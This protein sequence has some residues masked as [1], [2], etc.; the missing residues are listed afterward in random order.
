MK[1]GIRLRLVISLFILTGMALWLTAV[2]L[3]K[4]AEQR[5][6]NHRKELAV[7][8]AKTLA[9]GSLDALVTGDFELLERWV[10]SS[11]PTK[12][13]AYAALVRPNGQVL[14]HTNLSLIGEKIQTHNK[15]VDSFIRQAQYQQRPV[16]EVLYSST[17]GKKHLANAHVAYYLDIPY[18]QDKE[19]F[20]RLI[21][22]MTA[23]SLF[24]M[25]GVYIVTD[26]IIKPIR[27]LSDDIS[28][29]TLEK[30]IRFSPVVYN[31][32]DEIGELAKSFDKL[33]YRLIRS[34]YDLKVS[35]DDAINA[36]ELAEYASEAKSDFIANISHE[37]RTPMHSILGF[38]ELGKMKAESP[39]K[40]IMYFEMI[41]QSGSRLLDLIN[42]LLD[43]SK[44]GAGEYKINKTENDLLPLVDKC[45]QEMNFLLIEKSIYIS[46]HSE[47]EAIACFDSVAI[48]RVINNLMSNAIKYCNS[49]SEIVIEVSIENQFEEN[50]ESNEVL[51]FKIRDEGAGIPEKEL[52]TIFDN[53]S[54][55]STTKDGAGGTGLGLTISKRIIEAHH[56]KLWAENSKDKSG[57]VFHFILP[58]EQTV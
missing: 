39:E 29:F 57:V 1:I 23:A 54:Q 48:C 10:A 31:R 13:Y 11:L 32:K 30:G 50:D 38:S 22:I 19:T 20:Y 17:L 28:N 49:E 41:R 47:K 46:L 3:I 26:K 35:H 25:I 51:H 8:Q 15:P 2:V 37:L 24:L 7:H 56:G 52:L 44:L 27:H 43:T 9:E 4:D 42:D 45:E 33:S 6:D 40:V 5:L 12:E 55:S 36:K 16:L 34:Y 18:Q 14:T 53:F 21:G 58:V